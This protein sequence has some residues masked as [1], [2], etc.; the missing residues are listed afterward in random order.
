MTTFVC[1]DWS[2]EASRRAVCV[3]DTRSR[4]AWHWRFPHIDFHRVLDAA[5]ALDGDVVIGFDC[6]LGVPES[7]LAASH[8]PSFEALLAHL[9][10]QP[11]FA[12]PVDSV[13]AWRLDRPFFRV[14][15]GAGSRGL[16]EACAARQGVVLWRDIDRRTGA[17]PVFITAGIPGSVGSGALAL[18][19]QL[20][21]AMPG[22]TFG[23]WPFDGADLDELLQ[24]RRVVVGEIY[25]R[26]AYALAL[27][28]VPPHQRSRLRLAKTQQ[29]ARETAL[30]A[31][32]QRP[33]VK[34]HGVTIDDCDDA[35]ASE[36]VFDA[37]LTASAFLRCALEG[38]SVGGPAAFAEGGILL[39]GAVNLALPEIQWPLKATSMARLT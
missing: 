3:A 4:R 21:V 32:L 17:N 34:N 16:F 26:V 6:A 5:S 14:P 9:A 31:L 27:L 2:K 20:A 37:L 11:D 1:A 15:A 29:R 36:D 30:A 25:P 38:R 13:A 24:R 33:W 23:L 19:Q 28:D 39:T 7:F 10:A 8:L 35:V 22:R 12:R 18:W